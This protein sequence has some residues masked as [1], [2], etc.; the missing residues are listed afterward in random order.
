MIE[1]E[2]KRAV[3]HYIES[4]I[5]CLSWHKRLGEI[6]LD[7]ALKQLAQAQKWIEKAK[8]KEL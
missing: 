1:D 6:T 8:D 5:L 2:T 7:D 4:A 3:Y